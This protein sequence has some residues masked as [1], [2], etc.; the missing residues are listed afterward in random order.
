MR[1][2]VVVYKVKC[3]MISGLFVCAS[4]MSVLKSVPIKHICLNLI[5]VNLNTQKKK[6]NKPRAQFLTISSVAL[7]T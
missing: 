4:S 6:K 3:G 1:I 7:P 2:H 5:Q